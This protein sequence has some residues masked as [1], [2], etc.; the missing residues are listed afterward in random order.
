[1]IRERRIEELPKGIFSELGWDYYISEEAGNYLAS[2]LVKITGSEADEFYKAGN[3]LYPML[4][5]AAEY[6][7]R[8]NL[9]GTMGIPENLHTIIRHTWENDNHFHLFGRFDFA[10]GLDNLPIKLLEFNADTPTTLP[11]TAILQWLQLKANH[12]PEDDQLNFVYDALVAN[13]K[14][15]KDLNSDKD[16]YILF[17]TMA[18]TP[19]DDNN[20]SLLMEAA[21]EAGFE[22][23][24]ESVEN[25]IFSEFDGI[26]ANNEDGEPVNYPF[27][28]KLIPWEYIAVDEPELAEILTRIV[29]KEKAVILNPAYTMLFQSKAI[30]KYLWELFPKH[31]LL[32]ESSFSKPRNGK[33]YVEKVVLGREGA[34]VKIVDENGQTTDEQAGDYDGQLKIYQHYADLAKDFRG[35]YYQAGLFYAYESCGLGFRRNNHKIL[36]NSAQFAGHYID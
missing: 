33:A 16:P 29:V 31:D 30:L 28:F 27:W 17:S 21:Y 20:V 35:N 23:S 4:V 26:F 32:L 18:G 13:F 10:G 12:I 6:V 25:V 7:L 5:D 9:L 15:L 11:E 8:N 22:V 3:T 36:N 1:M 34:N 2:D 19:E 24:F 14:R